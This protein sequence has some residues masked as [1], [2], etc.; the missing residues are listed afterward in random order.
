M[1]KKLLPKILVIVGPT[2]IGKSSLGMRLA[3]DFDGEIIGADS[4]QVYRRMS[5]GTAKPSDADRAEIPHHLVD[6]IDPDKRYSLALFIRDAKQAIHNTK[7][8]R[9]RLP[10]VV[11]GTGQYIWG[12]FEGWQVP[13]VKPNAKIRDSLER[14]LELEGLATLY[15]E[16]QQFDQAAAARIDRRNPR[17]VVRALEVALSSTASTTT[18]ST[19]EQQCATGYDADR[20]RKNLPGF[21]AMVI[22]VTMER[23]A[24][25]DCIDNRIDVQMADGWLEEVRQLRDNGYGLQHSALSGLGYA[26][27]IRHMDGELALDEAVQRIKFRTHNY[28]RKQYNWFRLSDERIHWLDAPVSDTEYAR[29]TSDVRAWLEN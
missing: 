19:N 1:A 15:G 28:A 17:R 4:R 9:A 29:L 18:A 7:N 26:E 2:G 21:D 20:A 3:H 24:L 11:G 13:Q 25:Y 14:R 27:L 6:I 16:L 10:I 12:L 22:G 8:A 5:I 23:A